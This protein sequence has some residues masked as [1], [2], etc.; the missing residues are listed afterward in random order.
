MDR[1]ALILYLQNVRDLEV[2]RHII[3]TS[4]NREKSYYEGQIKSIQTNPAIKKITKLEKKEGH[5]LIFCFFGLLFLFFLYALWLLIQE[6]IHGEPSSLEGG[7]RVGVIIL[8]VVF[9]LITVSALPESE[10][11]YKKRQ[12]EE[13]EK[14]ESYNNEQRIIFQRGLQH[15]EE[16]QHE[17]RK[18]E[19]WYKKEYAKVTNIL[20]RF[21]EMNILES[22]YRDLKP[23]LFIYDYMRTGQDTFENAKIH[24]RI[25][26]GI[27]QILAKLDVLIDE[28][29]EQIYETRC[30]RNENRLRVENQ[31]DQNNKMLRH[32]QSI[33]I[34]SQETA[35]Y[36]Q[37]ASNYS[38]ANAYFSLA[39]YLKK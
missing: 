4:F 31:I 30:L 15:R 34:N 22:D 1:N 9:G 26:N 12:K 6:K 29:R 21:Y 20:T 36:S 37:L 8:T 27:E 32:L 19:S 14:I 28:V 10:K 39:S 33:S 25:E 23:V 16:L 18:K 38:K 13:E 24:W 2:A 5:G 3:S 17:W 35:Y 11:A 7:T